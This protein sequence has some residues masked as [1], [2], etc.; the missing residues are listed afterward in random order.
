M[1]AALAPE[2]V[3]ILRGLRVS[4][5]VV[6]I[7][8][9]LDRDLYVKVNKALEA[10]G[11]KWNRKIRGHVFPEDPS[12]KLMQAVVTE[13]VVD[14]KKEFGFFETP[15][16]LASEIV[17]T[18]DL[19]DRMRVLEPSAG[20]GAIADVV[21]Y[22]CPGCRL[23]VVEIQEENRK[24]LKG[25]GHRLVGK[26]FMKFKKKGYD[27]I[28]MNPPFAKQQDIA[29]VRHAFSLLKPGGRLVSV[30]GASV[31]F[32]SD[33]KAVSFREFLEEHGATVVDL[34]PETFREAGTLVNAVLVTVD[35]P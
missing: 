7:D 16:T 2:I 28:V 26:D 25:K 17:L 6:Y 12:E 8:Q 27:R 33:K 5:N 35:K 19:G 32:R 13:K 34:P 3:E 15:D 11:G 24:V 1:P 20:R 30:M 4:G 21:A 18:A 22:M 31:K 23:E 10:L 29:H 14:P 9:Q